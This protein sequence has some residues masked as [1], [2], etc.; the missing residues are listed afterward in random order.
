[1][2]T[3][4]PQAK[5]L[6]KALGLNTE[7]FLKHEDLHP[8]GSHKGRS[9]PPMIHHYIN[10]GYQNFCISSS[11]NAALAAIYSIQELNKGTITKPLNL[12]I[13]IGKH[14]PAEK[15]D[16]LKNLIIDS[17]NITIKQ[18]DNPKQLAFQMEKDGKAK[19]L[20]QSTD[21][22]ALIGYET[23]A[24]ELAEIK[25]L[26]AVFIPT[27]SGTTAQGLD[28][29]FK[30]LGLNPQI[31]IVQT[32]ACHPMVE[33]AISTEL[34]LASAI[35]DKVAY[36][37]EKVKEIIKETAGNGWIATNEEI[38]NAKQIIKKTEN[39]E[40]SF[41]SALSVAGL[42]LALQN[43]WKFSGAVVCILTGR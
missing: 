33:S 5:Q 27:S 4:Q 13:F 38:E 25:N 18:V 15:L 7:L 19:N 6:A 10:Q 2:I 22:V 39:I 1:M 21:D 20:R 35:V 28:N 11:G 29:A 14:I 36:R 26:S 31:H 9:I 42:N 41:N 34:S 37:K 23:L 43:N 40:V 32:P 16:V 30:N 17:K 8:Y 12:N 3:P 24:K